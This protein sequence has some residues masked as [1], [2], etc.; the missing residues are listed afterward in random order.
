MKATLYIPL[1]LADVA[2]AVGHTPPTVNVPIRAVV[3]DSREA[4]TGVLFFAL[5]GERFDGNDFIE[6]AIK[7]GAAAVS[8][9]LHDGALTVR[10]TRSALLSLAKAY[11]ERLPFLK[12]TVAVT[13]SVGK[14][15]TKELLSSL[16]SSSLHV[17]ATQAN[18]NNE[19][20][21]S[22][23]V[24]SAPINTEALVLE[25]G[26]NH[27][28]EMLPLAKTACADIAVLTNV[29][30]AHIGNFGGVKQLVAEKLRVGDA[31]SENGILLVPDDDKRLC[32]HPRACP[33]S[34]SDAY[35]PFALLTER[36]HGNEQEAVF[37]KD[38]AAL[39]AVHL[40]FTDEGAYRGCALAMAAA[41]LCGASPL[42]FSDS[43]KKRA[44]TCLRM[45]VCTFFG[46]GRVLDDTYNASPES[47]I[48]ALSVLSKETD[49]M[50][51]VLLGDM[52]ELGAY[53]EELHRTIGK[54]VHE[55]GACRAFFYGV[56]APFYRM[57]AL[58]AG[59]PPE[60]IFINNDITAPEVT[61]QQ[62]REHC[63]GKETLL[64]KASRGVHLE[65]ILRSITV[66]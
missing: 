8:S 18:Y 14:T 56:Y 25:L 60:H 45:K 5:Q 30:H 17:H 13:G 54:K 26:I 63:N 37:C 35:A 31:L 15:T 29:G 53:T 22:M 40:P 21:L 23:T 1:T 10:D 43:L 7:R 38:G 66:G 6:D 39:A 47:V 28:G 24:L 32:A 62:I 2:R 36:M 9:K 59:M 57:G 41:Y 34:V 33:V 46:G 16:L 27:P 3:T 50:R 61:V 19:I 11:R 51:C 65:N 44:S 4:E 55:C 52:R 49:T 20:G 12:K 48:N 64:C 58:E 42:T